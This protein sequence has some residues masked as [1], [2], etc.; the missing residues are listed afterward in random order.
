MR[1]HDYEALAA[2][3]G[4]D[5]AGM[6]SDEDLASDPYREF[7]AGYEEHLK[8]IPPKLANRLR[9]L[10]HRNL[11]I[12][13]QLQR[14]GVRAG[15]FTLAP[16]GAETV[17]HYL[18][19]QGPQEAGRFRS[20]L[21]GSTANLFLTVFLDLAGVV[22]AMFGILTGGNELV[23]ASQAFT[24][25]LDFL[26]NKAK[27]AMEAASTQVQKAVK[28]I[29]SFLYNLWNLN[30]LPTLAWNYFRNMSWWK[31]G[32][33]VISFVGQCAAY[34]ASG[35]VMIALKIAQ[36]AIAIAQLIFDLTHLPAT[37]QAG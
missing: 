27:L 29:F 24:N 6:P 25:I 20:E 8:G 11:H 17:V 34:V 30:A 21:L 32:L 3:N 22:G 19:P 7:V 14:N 31:I 18:T 4:I 26:G 37:E 36:I 10:A 2:R 12:G 13:M 1:Y 9:R 35:G 15:T 5:L 23:R 28:A 33:N 16:S